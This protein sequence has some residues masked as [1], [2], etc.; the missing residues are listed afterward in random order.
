MPLLWLA[1]LLLPVLP[2]V[3]GPALVLWWGPRVLPA[4]W[5][6]GAW[7]A[8]SAEPWRWF[9][10]GMAEALPA[11]LAAWIFLRH[12]GG[13]AA[14][15]QRR[16]LLRFIGF[17]CLM[18]LA[19]GCMLDALCRPA[20]AQQGW[21]ALLVWRLL[22]LCVVVVPLLSLSSAA[23]ARRGWSRLAS[24]ERVRFERIRG[25]RRLEL[26]LWL[27]LPLLLGY[28]LPLT[29]YYYGYGLL[30]LLVALR[31][32]SAGAL[33]ANG[34]LAWLIL[35]PLVQ[36][37]PADSELDVVVWL[38]STSFIALVCGSTIDSLRRAAMAQR[39]SAAELAAAERGLRRYRQMVES[40]ADLMSFIDRDGYYRIANPALCRS[41][42]LPSSALIDRPLV[43]VWGED[44]VARYQTLLDRVMQ[45]E[46]L[47]FQVWT[48]LP[49]RGRC[50]LDVHYDPYRDEQGLIVGMLVT[51]RDLTKEAR[52][53]ELL[54]QTQRLAGV[55]GWEYLPDSGVCL[56]SEELFRLLGLDR[57][58]EPSLA[59]IGDCLGLVSR[60]IWEEAVR[61][62]LA[63]GR[64]FDLELERLV[65]GREAQMLRMTA[66]PLYD[67]EAMV[68]LIG[69]C[70]DV[71]AHR[72]AE[73]NWRLA[74][75]VFSTSQESILITDANRR[76]VLT[77]DAFSRVS[78]YTAEQ[79]LGREPDFLLA[80]IE[81]DEARIA[82]WQLVEA[83]NPWQ[84][85][86]WQ[87]RPDIGT[88]PVWCSITPVFDPAQRLTNHIVMFTDISARR[89]AEAQVEH[90]AHYDA[91][92]DLP[93][94]VLFSDRATQALT[95]AARS[96]RRV[97]LLFIDLDRFKHIN[98]SLG[99]GVGDEVL[100][101]VSTRLRWC[102]R[103]SDT[104]SRLGGD[105][106]VVLLPELNDCDDA[107]AVAS[108]ILDTTA[109]PFQV[110]GHEL[111]VTPSIGIA[112]YPDH[113]EDL[114]ALLKCADTAMYHAKS[115]GRNNYQFFAPALRSYGFE[116]LQ[117]EA[118]LRRAIERQEFVLHYQPQ[119]SLG[120]GALIGVE[121]LVR[122]HHPEHGLVAPDRFIPLAEESG[123][124]VRLG[125]WVLR[126]A[127]RQNRAWQMAGLASVPVAVNLSAQQFR[128]DICALVA[129]ALDESQLDPACLE[130]E[131]TE[132]VLMDD[133]VLSTLQALKR[134]G[135]GL[136]IDDFGTGYS[137]LGYLKRFPLDRLKVDRSFVADIGQ[138]GDDEAI[139]QAIVQL[140]RTLRLRVVAEGV[141]AWRQWRFL[142]A[143]GCDDVQGFLTGRPVEA[144]ELERLWRAWRPAEW[145]Q[146][147]S[148]N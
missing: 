45:G 4:L 74:A 140:G 135:V 1:G 122:W 109:W 56:W 63:N 68:R 52:L 119:V 9:G 29:E 83:G 134:M 86:L 80:Q 136:S 19:L 15:T 107:A 12:C 64:P 32:G 75:Q 95:A 105:E 57:Q 84:G 37:G 2:M 132:R 123:L 117:W 99:H 21:P 60:G 108:K 121:A 106:F 120:S 81:D 137:S 148:K 38:A 144:G 10:S 50:F 8:D 79:A 62:A 103:G 146:H 42:D 17:A 89:A 6:H 125:E 39:A 143:I 47:D 72:A 13:E 92:T 93:N 90:L 115:S 18:P 104:V 27:A 54:Q 142:A 116:L 53:T 102:L 145:L 40:S 128:Q 111:S 138:D 61:E 124:I 130:L 31:F 91:L 44:H 101:Q 126:E 147:H 77:N 87:R 3:L 20:A 71:T 133:E 51:S 129:A 69:A 23:L 59:A 30:P 5:L 46:H 49:G 97:A 55:G 85:E 25:W 118:A 113:G 76:I 82:R 110:E 70:Q 35:T 114:D 43:E 28:W 73:A 94:R 26:L 36:H 33:L 127:C 67:G 139:V 22:L 16:D 14:L 131:L 34:W 96:G 41:L 65:R 48:Q 66:Q 7:M 58:T 24:H 11:G 98:D 100:R 78:G 88:Y 141:E 112:L